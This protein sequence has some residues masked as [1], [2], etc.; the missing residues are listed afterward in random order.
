MRSWVVA[1][2]VLAVTACLSSADLSGAGA[3]G[4]APATCAA[5][6]QTDVGHCGACGHVCAN[7]ANAYGVCTTGSCAIGCNTSF[8]DCDGKPENGCEVP[9]TTDANHCGTCGHSCGG[10]TCSDGVCQPLTIATLDGTLTSFAFE[11]NDL[12]FGLQGPTPKSGSIVRVDRDGQG[13]KELV[14]GLDQAPPGLAVDATH[15]Y[16]SKRATT[17]STPDGTISRLPRDGSAEPIAI[18]TGEMIGSNAGFGSQPTTRLSLD[19]RFVYYA[20]GTRSIQQPP[21]AP[22]QIIDGRLLRVPVEG[23]ASFEVSKSVLGPVDFLIDGPNVFIATSGEQRPPDYMLMGRGLFRCATTGCASAPTKLPIPDVSLRVLGVNSSVM[24]ISANNAI[25]SLK[26]TGQDYALFTATRSLARVIAADDD[27]VYWLDGQSLFSCP[28][29]S[30]PTGPIDIDLRA[31]GNALVVTK[32][33]VYVGA[34]VGTTTLVLR[35]TR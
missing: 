1:F 24:F 16:F 7:R 28:A 2:L 22:A 3:A 25:N 20:V 10:G 33:A 9:L 4:G 18:V 19:G 31:S 21:P 8:A 13:R 35:V 11:G 23:G 12:Y 34:S 26:K 14:A 6:L 29:A 15:L 32:E 27:R 5:D 30:C 17:T